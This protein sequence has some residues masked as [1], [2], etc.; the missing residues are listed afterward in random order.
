MVE[1]LP[2]MWY[3]LIQYEPVVPQRISFWVSNSQEVSTRIQ[4]LSD[5]SSSISSFLGM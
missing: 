2:L 1:P 3:R 4:K 5:R